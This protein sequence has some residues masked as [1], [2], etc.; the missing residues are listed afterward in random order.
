MM[1]NELFNMLM[2]MR[3][4]EYFKVFWYDHKPTDD[5]NGLIY[6]IEDDSGDYVEWFKTEEERNLELQLIK[7]LIK[8]NANEK[9]K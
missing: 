5:N 2:R 6:G 4:P 3:K 8:E 9:R 7:E 1:N